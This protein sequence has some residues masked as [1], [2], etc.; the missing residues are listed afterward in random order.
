MKRGRRAPWL[1]LLIGCLGVGLVVLLAGPLLIPLPGSRSGLPPE[2]L[3]DPDSRFMDVNGLRVHH[4]AAG[5]GEPLILLLH[6]FGASVFSWRE[7]MAPLAEHGTVVAYDRPAFGLTQRPMPGEWGA[8]NPYTAPAQARLA[9]DLVLALGAERAILVGHS[10][11]GPIAMLAALTYPDRV[12]ALILVD[13]A[14]YVGFSIPPFLRPL[15][16]TPQMRRI[17][18][19]IARSIAGRSDEFARQAWHDPARITPEIM[20]GYVRP[21]QVQNWERALWEHTAA[22]ADV[23]LVE[24]L[25]E[26]T[27]PILVITGDDDRVLPAELSIQLANALPNARYVLIGDC[28]HVPQEE[29]PESFM[30]AVAGFLAGLELQEA[31]PGAEGSP[32]SDSGR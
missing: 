14:V 1:R 4:K 25:D 23:G 20:E 30:E 3:A 24:R 2:E 7:V 22:S 13:P 12:R 31:G 5:E 27:L 18:P 15:L 6:G 11:G 26:L 32:T 8:G 21:L 17:G 28:G 9:A 16:T 29:C 19:W 10:A